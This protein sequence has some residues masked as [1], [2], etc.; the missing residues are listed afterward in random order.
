MGNVGGG[1]ANLALL[2]KIEALENTINESINNVIQ[3]ETIL[4]G[5]V[6]VPANSTIS[7]HIIPNIPEG[8][9]IAAAFSNG[10]DGHSKCNVTFLNIGN[11]G[12]IGFYISNTD[13][14]EHTVKPKIVVIF[15]K[16]K[17][18]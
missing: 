17:E 18:E 14:V 16:Y 1:N 5:E 11:D 2:Q 12:Y 15:Q 6:S 4:S 9:K 7:S 3:F 13:S 8:Y 10:C